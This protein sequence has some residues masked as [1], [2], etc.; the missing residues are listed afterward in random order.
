MSDPGKN[1]D[2]KKTY[3]RLCAV[4]TGILLL[5]LSAVE[6]I[7]FRNENKEVDQYKV[8]ISRVEHE[9]ADYGDRAGFQVDTAKYETILGV[10]EASGKSAEEFYDS[11]EHYALRVINGKM[12][13]IEYRIDLSDRQRELL[14][15]VNIFAVILLACLVFLMLYIYF[16]IIKRFHQLAEYPYDLAKGNLTVPLKEDRNKYFGRFTWGLDMLREKLEQEKEENLELQKEKSLMLLSL[17]H[18][19]KTPL[20][21]IRL[22]AAAMKKRLYKDP[23]KQVEIA[24][25]IDDNVGEIEDYVS[26]IVASTNEDFLR[27]DVKQ[28]EFYLSEAI[29]HI[30]TYY[31]EKLMDI[32]ME[33]SV[34]DYRDLLI[35]GD[36]DRFVEVLQ[37]LMENALKYGDGRKIGI[38]FRDEEG[39]RL[40]S[41]SNTGPI[42]PEDE[43]EHIFDSFYRGS[44]VGNRKGSG[45]GLYISRKLMNRMSGDIYAEI[46]D[47]MMEVTLVCCP[48]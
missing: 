25:R 15:R 36:K 37:N 19:I 29:N 11:P 21:A 27:F 33:L 43:L 22:Y 34:G 38:R 46:V 4:I 26:K 16:A 8:E 35:R 9:I 13:R 1:A 32:G 39:A 28:G 2:M 17:S 23:E 44:N 30:R 40:V 47:G 12:Y 31:S 6:F 18:D 48:A 5:I 14:I 20:A 41:V 42:L 24:G 7:A 10:Y 3:I 45:L